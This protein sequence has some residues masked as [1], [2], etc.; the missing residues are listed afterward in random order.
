MQLAKRWRRKASYYRLEGQRHRTTGEVR[1]P[2]RSAAPGETAEDWERHTLSG[3]GEIYSFSVL[4]QVPEGFDYEAPYPVAMIRLDEG[5]LVVAQLTD[6]GE[7]ELSIGQRVEMVT[8]KL[9]DTGEDGLLVYAYK[10]RP[11]LEG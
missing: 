5:P 2:P 4:R 1:F 7:A 10:F 9:K 6:C 11:L 3:K 8:R